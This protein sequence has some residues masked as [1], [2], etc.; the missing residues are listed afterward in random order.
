MVDVLGHLPD[1][2][3]VIFSNTSNNPVFAWIPGK[4]RY[5]TCM[6][7]VNE[8]QFWRAIFSILWRLLFINSAKIEFM[9]IISTYLPFMSCLQILQLIWQ[10]RSPLGINDHCR[11][12]DRVEYIWAEWHFL[13]VLLYITTT[14]Q[15][16]L[17]W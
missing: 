9:C 4:I 16:Q 6:T 5:F 13:W 7:T 11:L 1:L 2:K 17:T 8:K 12:K 10:N 3:N 14:L 15:S